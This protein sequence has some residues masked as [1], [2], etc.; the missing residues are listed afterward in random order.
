MAGFKKLKLIAVQASR[1]LDIKSV[2]QNNVKL[3]RHYSTKRGTAFTSGL[4]SSLE[5]LKLSDCRPSIYGPISELLLSPKL[6]RNLK[7]IEVSFEMPHSSTPP[8]FG[9]LTTK[10]GSS[11]SHVKP[12]GLPTN[13]RRRCGRIVYQSPW[14][15]GW[16]LPGMMRCFSGTGINRRRRDPHVAD[17]NIVGCTMIGW[18]SHVWVSIRRIS[19][20]LQVADRCG[21]FS[22]WCGPARNWPQRQNWPQISF[23]CLYPTFN[24]LQL[25]FACYHTSPMLEEIGNFEKRWY[26]AGRG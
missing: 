9:D 3:T 10:C 2:S 23:T 13:E 11:W 25:N 8:L 12:P 5:H 18:R 17:R 19:R 26:C 16:C 7:T 24:S 21:P 22:R 4:P 15:R 14:K 20:L 1:I 6:P